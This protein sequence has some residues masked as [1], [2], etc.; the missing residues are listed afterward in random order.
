MASRRDGFDDHEWKDKIKQEQERQANRPDGCR[1]M[2]RTKS[3]LLTARSNAA[4]AI[5]DTGVS[6]G[7]GNF[8]H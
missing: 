6:G 2:S 1:P 4:K 3:N 5:D 7:P 8:A